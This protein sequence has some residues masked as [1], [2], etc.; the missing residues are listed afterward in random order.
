MPNQNTKRKKETKGVVN[1]AKDAVEKAKKKG[2]EFLYGKKAEESPGK[3]AEQ[4]RAKGDEIV[5]ALASARP[6]LGRLAG[7]DEES[8][9]QVNDM[10]ASVNALIDSIKNAPTIFDNIAELDNMLLDAAYSLKTAGEKGYRDQA[11]WCINALSSGMVYLRDNIPPQSREHRD[12]IIRKRIDYMKNYANLIIVYG[13]IDENNE[14]IDR[15]KQTLVEVERE[16][17]PLREEILAMRDTPEGLKLITSVKSKLNHQEKLTQEEQEFQLRG[18]RLGDLASDIARSRNLLYAKLAD[19]NTQYTIALGLR[20]ALDNMPA[21]YDVNMSAEY[22]AMLKTTNQLINRMLTNAAEV[23][24]ITRNAEDEL[25][26]IMNSESGKIVAGYSNEAVEK[27]LFPE[28]AISD[29]QKLELELIKARSA[30]KNRE[31]LENKAKLEEYVKAAQAQ[32]QIN[33]NVDADLDV[34][35]N[36]V[37]DE[38]H[39]NETVVNTEEQ[40]AVNIN[41]NS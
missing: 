34:L 29:A 40:E 32:E 7:E 27:I 31:Q 17:A 12:E 35:T 11:D 33:A 20:N 25:R 6:Y 5:A 14:S 39:A 19:N 8:K 16:Y 3:I 23:I 21:L 22:A 2:K 9:A 37:L 41:Y 13:K 26:Q 1:S 15:M 18:Q 30:Q 4:N 24:N 10:R 36:N 38:I 28:N